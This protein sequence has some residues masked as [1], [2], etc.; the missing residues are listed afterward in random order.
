MRKLAVS[1]AAVAGCLARCLER[2]R[3]VGI[4]PERVVLDPGIGFFRAGPILWSEWDVEILAHLE[5]FLE[6]G[7][8]LGVGVSRKS[9]IGALTGR[10]SPA[11]RLPGSLAATALAVAHGAS[12]IRTHDVR[13]T[14]DAVRVATRI[15]DA[16]W[17]APARTRAT[18]WR[19]SCGA[20]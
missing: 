4:A 18:S 14:A 11:D 15:R 1:L 2:A 16:R 3:G 19:R 8:P 17:T 7:R 12:L 9:F 20:T 13:E 10:A 5:D 6:L